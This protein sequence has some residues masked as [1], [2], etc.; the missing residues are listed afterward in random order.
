M[1]ITVSDVGSNLGRNDEFVSVLIPPISFQSTPTLGYT[2]V[3]TVYAEQIPGGNVYTWT[4]GANPVYVN[5]FE[6]W[7]VASA[8]SIEDTVSPTLNSGTDLAVQAR[9]GN[10]QFIAGIVVGVAGG[11]LVVALQEWLDCEAQTEAGRAAAG[12]LTLHLS[13]SAGQ[14]VSGSVTRFGASREP[15][16]GTRS[17]P[18]A[19]SAPATGDERP[20]IEARLRQR[21]GRADAR[22]REVQR[23]VGAAIAS[24]VVAVG[25]VGTGGPVPDDAGQAWHPSA[26]RHRGWRRSAWRP[27]GRRCSGRL[28]SGR[29]GTGR[30]QTERAPTSAR[31]RTACDGWRTGAT[32]MA[33]VP[34]V[35]EPAC[36]FEAAA[37]APGR[38]GTRAPGT[39]WRRRAATG[40]AVAR[41]R[42]S[43]QRS[44]RIP[45]HRANPDRRGSDLPVS[46]IRHHARR[47]APVRIGLA[48]SHA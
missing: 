5:G 41:R 3:F 42:Q 17:A 37:A 2:K 45:L 14:R 22:R 44:G 8:G 48:D 38:T 34:M 21:G 4:T 10:L 43:V 13:G 1:S 19:I 7:T 15:G 11:A 33:Q 29:R 26:R 31:R 20:G 23:E 47:R 25:P 9:N 27:R 12:G 36:P 24:R 16:P 39:R 32:T 35:R 6:R 40:R 28:E 46:I 30:C 18:T